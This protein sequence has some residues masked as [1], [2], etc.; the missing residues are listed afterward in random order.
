[1]YVVDT[2]NDLRAPALHKAVQAEEARTY[3]YFHMK[4]SHADVYENYRTN[5]S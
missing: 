4:A 2:A 5:A 3:Y 1:M